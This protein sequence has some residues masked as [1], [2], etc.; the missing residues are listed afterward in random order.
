MSLARIQGRSVGS[1]HSRAARQY[2]RRTKLWRYASSARKAFVVR[3]NVQLAAS[4][5]GTG[6]RS[7]TRDRIRDCFFDA[8]HRSL[9]VARLATLLREC[10]CD[11]P[12]TARATR[13]TSRAGTSF[14]REQHAIRAQRALIDTCHDVASPT[15][16]VASRRGRLQPRHSF[17][18]PC[19]IANSGRRSGR[20]GRQQT[21]AGGLTLGPTAGRRNSS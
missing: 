19:C 3:T 12:H 6:A 20:D 15:R 18:P 16:C 14:P 11:T 9:S 13:S 2:V 17:V 7:S 5:G 21:A 10:D 4:V 8:F 1:T